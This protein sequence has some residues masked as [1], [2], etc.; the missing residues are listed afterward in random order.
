MGYIVLHNDEPEKGRARYYAL[1][2]TPEI[3]GQGWVVARTWGPL[4]SHRRQQKNS[5]VEDGAM[6]LAL[7]GRHLRRRLRHGY[8]VREASGEGHSLAGS[9]RRQMEQAATPIKR[10]Q[11]WRRT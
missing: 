6:A 11:Q 1:V 2:W 10:K 4:H 8:A 5:F 9:I 7:A 3:T